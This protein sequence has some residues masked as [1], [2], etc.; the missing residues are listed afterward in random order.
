M[1]CNAVNGQVQCVVVQNL[2][3]VC[4]QKPDHFPVRPSLS[5]QQ[6]Q[7]KKPVGNHSLCFSFAINFMLVVSSFFILILDFLCLFDFAR[8][9][10]SGS[11]CGIHQH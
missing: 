2:K 9:W 1:G 5:S 6:A 8:L 10:A 4:A 3:P 11:W 7:K